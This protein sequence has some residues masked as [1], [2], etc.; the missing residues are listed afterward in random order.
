MSLFEVSF[1]GIN[2]DKPSNISYFS[3]N[4]LGDRAGKTDRNQ[5][6]GSVGMKTNQ[7]DGTYRPPNASQAQTLVN[8]KKNRTIP[9]F[10][11]L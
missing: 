11:D 1:Y 9:P 5:S 6:V 4:M 2:D 10:L 7:K 3:V 8:I